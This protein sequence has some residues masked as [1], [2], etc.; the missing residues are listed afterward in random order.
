MKKIFAATVGVALS[1]CAVNAQS[2]KSNSY[3]LYSYPL[4][5]NTSNVAIG[6]TPT[7]S[8]ANYK[9][10]VKG[11]SYHNGTTYMNGA[12]TINSTA[13]VNSSL[14]VSGTSTL[15][16]NLTCKGTDNKFYKMLRVYATDE[17]NKV[18]L[19]FS[20]DNSVTEGMRISSSGKNNY[21]DL[22]FSAMKYS[23]NVE[24]T[25]INI[26]TMKKSGINM[27]TNL[28]VA[29]KIKC[30]N[31]LEV[32]DVLK[33][34]QIK[35]QDI[36]VELNNAADYVFEEGYNLRSLSEVENYVKENKHLPGVPSASEISE[37]GMSVSQMSNL[38]LEKVEELTLHMIEL[39]KENKALRNRVEMLEK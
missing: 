31:E 8:T 38:L 17:A 6:I 35:A 4:T 21:A 33:A 26:M 27:M 24:S 16:G 29:G 28:D 22:S 15:N 5:G 25:N 3:G 34:T 13:K 37:N 10:Y 20:K 23:F 9:L 1:V 14:T 12:V 2:W 7:S 32:A 11:P 19:Y 36:N 39:E 30:Q 18:N